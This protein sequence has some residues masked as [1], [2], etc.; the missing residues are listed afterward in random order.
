MEKYNIKHLPRE[1][2]AKEGREALKDLLN[3]G[4]TEDDKA[5]RALWTLIDSAETMDDKTTAGACLILGGILCATLAIACA[6]AG[7]GFIFKHYID[8]A[9]EMRHYAVGFSAVTILCFGLV[10]MTKGKPNGR[11]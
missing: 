1:E 6:L 8:S 11:N 9:V 4:K 10:R 7:C 2:A 3:E 5:V